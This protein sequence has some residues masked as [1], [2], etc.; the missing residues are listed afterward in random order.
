VE[1]VATATGLAGDSGKDVTS[2]YSLGV[3]A[4]GLD[5]SILL[6]EAALAGNDQLFNSGTID[7]LSTSLAGAAG[8][9]VTI[10]GA[11]SAELNSNARSQATG[12]DAGG[13]NDFVDSS[14]AVTAEAGSNAGALGVAFAQKPGPK[15]DAS[16][17]ASAKAEST[18]TGIAGDG[19][20]H[21]VVS[22]D[23]GIRLDGASFAAGREVTANAGDDVILA[24]ATFRNRQRDQRDACCHGYDRRHGQA[25]M[26]ATAEGKAAGIA[27][28]GGNDDISSGGLIT[29]DANAFAGDIAAAVG[30]QSSDGSKARPRCSRKPEAGEVHRHR[31]RRRVGRQRRVGHADDR[32][33]GPAFDFE[34]TSTAASGD[35]LLINTGDVN[36][37][38]TAT[39]AAAAIAVTIKGGA[40]VTSTRTP[41]PRPAASTAAAAPT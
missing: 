13:G 22:A 26:K 29:A 4:S 30:Q 23:I 25:E 16:A 32:R 10:D 11:S 20:L 34:K 6:D 24:A 17:E 12:I 1:A 35:D 27:G 9:S 36:S 31:R 18:A 19:G 15:E 7:A 39:T 8:V 5:L 21:V 14:G 33:G 28:G 40:K 37:T 3:D 41:R 2:T 38:A